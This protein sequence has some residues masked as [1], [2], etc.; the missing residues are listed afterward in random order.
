M[1]FRFSSSSI[2]IRRHIWKKEKGLK[3][4]AGV[5]SEGKE[6]GEREKEERRRRRVESTKMGR[7]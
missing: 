4:G 6:E 2:I 1:S 3:T 5:G 7:R